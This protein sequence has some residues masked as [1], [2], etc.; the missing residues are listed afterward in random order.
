MKKLI[1][2]AIALSMLFVTNASAQ[3]VRGS[4]SVSSVSSTQKSKKAQKTGI[5]YQGELNFG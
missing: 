3:I 1:L 2:A 5:R 4:S